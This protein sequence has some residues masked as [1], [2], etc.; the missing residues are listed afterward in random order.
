MTVKL[1]EKDAYLVNFNA[2]VASCRQA[3][4]LFEVELDQTA[5][6]P[7]GGGQPADTGLINQAPVLDVQTVNGSIVHKTNTAFTQGERVT[8]LVNWA[9]RFPRMQNHSGEHIVSGIIHARFGCNNVGFHMGEALMTL[10][11]DGALT[12]EQIALVEREANDVVYANRGISASFPPR[13]E[14]E[15]LKYRSKRDIGEDVRIIRIENCDCCACCAPHV[16]R[17][18]EI[19]LI[20]VLNFY[21]N[22]GGT[23]IELICGKDAFGDYCAMHNQNAAIMRSLSAKRKETAEAVKRTTEV[24]AKIRAENKALKEQLAFAQTV[25][26]K[27]NGVVFAFAPGAGYDELRYCS[28]RLLEEHDGVCYVFSENGGEYIYVV[29]GRSTDIKQRVAALNTQLNGTGGGKANYAQGKV[30][31]GKQEIMEFMKSLT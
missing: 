21:P 13:E 6:F 16:S 17:T 25:V 11:V 30:A 4:G 8:G 20:K 1:Y 5:F 26:T 7:E 19:G 28:N 23:R 27:R 24:L 22:K 3:G 2:V 12:A 18:G 15:K 9:A 29:A 14:L 10:D 31:A